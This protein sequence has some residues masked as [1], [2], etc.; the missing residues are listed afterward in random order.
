MIID[1]P[2][3]DITRYGDVRRASPLIA[4]V[5]G[6]DRAPSHK[7]AIPIRS[8]IHFLLDGLSSSDIIARASIAIIVI[9]SFI[10]GEMTPDGR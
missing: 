7:S 1:A 8:A 5:L 4:I 2:C 10:N 6:T 3:S 9:F